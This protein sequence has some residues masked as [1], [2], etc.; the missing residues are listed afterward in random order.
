MRIR[1]DEFEFEFENRFFRA[2]GLELSNERT[3]PH[4][5]LSLSLSLSLDLFVLADYT[6]QRTHASSHDNATRASVVVSVDEGGSGNLISI[7]HIVISSR[8]VW[9]VSSWWAAAKA[10]RQ[11]PPAGAAASKPLR[12]ARA[13]SACL[14]L[15]LSLSLD[16]FVM[17]D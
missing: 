7:G 8:L 10:G 13:V 14:S 11:P 3:P 9:G 4:M 16:L 15:S 12:G 17:A 5:S 2:G 6:E 1:R